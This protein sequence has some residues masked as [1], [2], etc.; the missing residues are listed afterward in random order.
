MLRAVLGFGWFA[1][2]KPLGLMQCCSA[3]ARDNYRWL[4]IES[5]LG[6]KL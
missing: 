1:N 5:K 2:D 4:W 3:T 6:S